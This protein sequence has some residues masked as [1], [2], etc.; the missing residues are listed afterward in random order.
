[1]LRPAKANLHLAAGERLAEVRRLA[2]MSQDEMARALGASVSGYRNYE[3][4]KRELPASLA[5]KVSRLFAVDIVWLLDGVGMSPAS[6][7]NA[8]QTALWAEAL[9]L[10]EKH[11]ISAGRTF[12]PLTK[13]KIVALVVSYTI[14]GRNEVDKYV[15]QLV[16]IAA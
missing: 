12:D 7:Q 10:V 16:E 8:N 13:A 1:M 9:E 3:R 5:T 6:R 14:D 15:A 11:L 2:Q 4:G